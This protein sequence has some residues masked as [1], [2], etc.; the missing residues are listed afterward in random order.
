MLILRA[1]PWMPEFGM[2]FEAAVLEEDAARAEPFVERADWSEPIAGER[3]P[4]E[5]VWFVDGVRRVEV[6]LGADQDGRRA[7]GLFGSHAVGS[8]CCDGRATFGE[9]RIG[10][11]VV[12]A[13]G[14]QPERVEVRVGANGLSC[15]PVSEPGSEPDRP[16]WRLQQ[17][18]RQAEAALAA[19]L[20]GETDRLVLVDGPL[21]L[22]DP[23]ACP[24]VGVVK[25][26]QRQYLD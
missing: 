10:R 24:V 23:T 18:M 14:L 11:V 2:G 3:G 22:R 5:P 16:L 12:L 9:H 20:A 26:S 7:P 19:N 25:R 4:P 6:R 1:D 21:T 17:V 15:E 8:V 13:S